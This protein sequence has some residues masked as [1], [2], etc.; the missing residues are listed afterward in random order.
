MYLDMRGIIE[1][2]EGG[3]LKS[4][5]DLCVQMLTWGTNIG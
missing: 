4:L 1:I 3:M 2:Q 5:I